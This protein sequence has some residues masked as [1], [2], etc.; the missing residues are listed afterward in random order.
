MG[1]GYTTVQLFK[2]D[3]ENWS[4]FDSVPL[5]LGCV[6]GIELFIF[7]A[8]SIFVEYQ[9]AFE[10]AINRTRTSTA[11]S[12]SSTSELTYDFDIGMGNNTMIGIVIYILKKDYTLRR[13]SVQ[14]Q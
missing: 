4:R 3:E 2:T 9:A 12:V 8:L 10:L 7:E 6:L 5:S 1:I 11:G 13:G 14:D